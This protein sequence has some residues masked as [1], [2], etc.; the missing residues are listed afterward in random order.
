MLVFTC[1]F[2]CFGRIQPCAV[3]HFLHEL[4]PRLSDVGMTDFDS[5]T[6]RQEARETER[7]PPRGGMRQFQRLNGHFAEAI[8]FLWPGEGGTDRESRNELVNGA[9]QRGIWRVGEAGR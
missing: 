7:A 9:T 3:T 1:L 2:A 4:C 6:C 8:E 5:S